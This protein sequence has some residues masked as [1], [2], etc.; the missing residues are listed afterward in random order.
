[1]GFTSI[2][3]CAVPFEPG[4]AED[5]ITLAAVKGEP[6]QVSSYP[7]VNG[8]SE[9]EIAAMLRDGGGTKT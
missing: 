1:V 4:K 5:R 7:W 6:V 2:L 8:K 3:E 9:E